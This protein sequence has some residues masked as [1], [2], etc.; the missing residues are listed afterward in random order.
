VTPCKDIRILCL[1]DDSDLGSSREMLLR[2]AGFEVASLPSDTGLSDG[3]ARRFDI[4]VLCHSLGEKTVTRLT[5]VLRR[6]NPDI[7]VIRISHYAYPRTGAVDAECST[8]DGPDGFLRT[9]ASVL[10]SRPETAESPAAEF[11]TADHPAHGSGPLSPV[12]I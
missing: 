4:A 11:R 2:N 7:R 9:V 5:G 1:C 10:G 6:L 12:K 8:E 3:L